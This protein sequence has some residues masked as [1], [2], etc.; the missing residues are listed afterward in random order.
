MV[1]FGDIKIKC[2]IKTMTKKFK[3]GNLNINLHFDHYWSTLGRMLFKDHHFG[4]YYKKRVSIG[5]GKANQG[6]KMFDDDNHVTTRTYGIALGWI[7]TSVS[8]TFG[9]IM[10]F[11]DTQP[12]R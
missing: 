5:S 9:N 1:S 10:I 6:M 3:I 12:H 2:Y 8:F 11:G 4:V 7:K